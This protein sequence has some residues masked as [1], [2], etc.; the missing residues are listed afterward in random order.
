M[1]KG[2][3]SG[4]DIQVLEGLEAVRK[5]T[6]H[7]HRLDR[8]QGP[9]PSRLRGR[10][11]LGRRGARGALHGDRD[12]HPPRQRD[13][14]R[15]QR[16][17]HPGRQRAQVPQAGRRGRSHRSARRRQVRRRGIQGLRRSS[18]R[19]R[20]G[21]QR[22]VLAARGRGQARRQDLDSGVRVR[23]AARAS[24]RPSGRSKATG[25]TITFWPTPR[26]SRRS[27]STS[28]RSPR[29]CARRRFSTRTSRS[30]SPTSAS[31]SPRR[32]EFR[33]AG[34]IVDFVKYLNERQGHAAPQGHLL[35]GRGRGRHRRGRHAVE[36]RLL[37]LGPRVRQQH[38][39]AR[40][41]HAPRGLQ[42]RAHAHDQRL[43]A[44][45]EHPQ[46]EGRQPLRRGH[47]RGAHRD[48][49]GQAARTRSSRGRPR[50]SSA[51]PRCAASC[52]R[53]SCRHLAEY[54]EEHPK[55]ARAIVGKSA[56]GG[57]GAR[58]RAQGARADAAQGA[59]REL[60]A[61]GQARRLLA[62]RSRAHRD[63]PGR[64]RLGRRLGQ[65]GARPLVPGDPAAQ[66][67]DPQRGEGRAS[68]GPSPPRR[69]RR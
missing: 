21:R 22:A 9:A 48:H 24:S 67:Q 43:R 7:V 15:R 13:H 23:Q 38:Q 65:A 64:G 45:A 46:G 52:S 8:A 30:R 51:T 47:P 4:K 31:S 19:R 35:R 29:A 63:L 34:G 44:P 40:G 41:R 68:T 12:H 1:S 17:R 3:Y 14:G 18:R 62:P 5:T 39:H 61:A 59:A 32:E 20:L 55:P 33:Y 42:E 60:D 37:G 53:P 6:R 57:Q 16:P 69:S 10:R 26:S 56:A 58:G 66:G 50:P 36:H 2:T 27:S 25:T 28:T 11:Q 54:L 49:L